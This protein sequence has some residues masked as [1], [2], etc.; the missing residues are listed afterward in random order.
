MKYFK[1][2]DGRLQEFD[3]IFPP[4]N[5]TQEEKQAIMDQYKQF[6]TVGEA[7]EYFGIE[8]KEQKWRDLS[9][10]I[11]NGSLKP[12]Y[13]GLVVYS[14]QNHDFN[15]FF[16]IIQAAILSV[17]EE[18]AVR[19]AIAMLLM[20]GYEFPLDQK[21]AWNDFVRANGFSEIVLLP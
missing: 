7:C 9:K 16:T 8:T 14:S 2:I 5:L 15:P 19:D 6:D 17:Q 20:A 4:D 18:T 12:L 1:V 13:E 10:E 21:T 3:E 11:L